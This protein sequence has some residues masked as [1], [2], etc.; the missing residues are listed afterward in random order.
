[1]GALLRARAGVGGRPGGPRDNAP[2]LEVPEAFN[3]AAAALLAGLPE[4][5]STP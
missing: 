3:A 5:P 2:F 4:H 1:M